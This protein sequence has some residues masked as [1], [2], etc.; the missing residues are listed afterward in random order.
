MF[1]LLITN[2]ANEK[3]LFA[4]LYILDEWKNVWKYFSCVYCIGF[5]CFYLT[6]VKMSN[7]LRFGEFMLE[8]ID[9]EI[10]ESIS[11]NTT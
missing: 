7:N 11:G 8:N 6:T 10:A 2:S 5:F 4:L 3:A 1:I 9:Q